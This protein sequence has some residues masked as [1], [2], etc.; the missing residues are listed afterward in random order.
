MFIL[1]AL[2]THFSQVDLIY[3]EE[4]VKLFI[5]IEFD[6]DSLVFESSEESN[7]LYIVKS[8]NVL[9]IQNNEIIDEYKEGDC[10]GDISLQNNHNSKL[11]DNHVYSQFRCSVVSELYLI[12]SIQLKFALK[13]N[14]QSKHDYYYNIINRIPLINIIEDPIKKKIIESISEVSTKKDT[15]LQMQKDKVEN[16]FYIIKGRLEMMDINKRSIIFKKGDFINE[17]IIIG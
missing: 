4:I 6:K 11:F 17:G 3:L 8:G 2:N 9:L 7:Y 5:H 14:I 16:I 10:F 1:K 12:S 15:L 13:E